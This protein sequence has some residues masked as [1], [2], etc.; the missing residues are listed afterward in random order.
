[1]TLVTTIKTSFTSGELDPALFG[2][3]DLR[4]FD[5][6]ARTLRNIVVEATGGVRRRP[7]LS[8]VKEA[9]RAL[10]L[11]A[12]EAA[13]TLLLFGDRTLA[14]IEA[15][16]TVATLTTAW[17]AARVAALDWTSIGDSLLLC[18]EEVEPQLLDRDMTGA[19]TLRSWSFDT[20]EGV[21]G[22]VTLGPFARYGAP[23]LVLQPQTP[24]F[25]PDQ[26]I[27]PLTTNGEPVGVSLKASRPFFHSGH[28]NVRFNLNGGQ[29]RII[30]VRDA[31]KADAIVVDGLDHGYAT[32]RFEEE[33]FS[34][35]R[36]WPIAVSQHQGRLVLGGSRDM[37]DHLWF[38][39]TGRPFNF[40]RGE[41]LADAS[42]AF[43]LQADRPHR[44]RHLHP[45]GRLQVFTTAGEWVVNGR[46]LTP[47]TVS[48]DAQ[49]QVGSPTGRK[50]RP[51]DVDGATLF[52][53][54]SGRD[55][56]EFIFTDTEQAYQAADIA[57]LS[58]H[59]MTAPKETAF[60][61]TGRLLFVVR[62]DGAFAAVTLD[63]NS[64]VVAWT[65]QATAGVALSVATLAGKAY[66][67]IHRFGRTFLEIWDEAAMLDHVQDRSNAT[68][69]E[70]WGGF[71]GFDGTGVTA[72]FE[73]GRS[74]TAK[75]SGG[76]VI[77]T[78]AARE[79]RLG[80]PYVHEIEPLP[81]S[82]AAGRSVAPDVLHRP[83]RHV[84]RL[85]ESEGLCLDTGTGP[86]EVRLPAPNGRGYT[87][88]VAVRALGWR[89]GTMQPPWRIVQEAPHP[90]RLLSVATE[91]K[92]S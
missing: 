85:F 71:A 92:V 6:G 76:E 48:I 12:F 64:N 46:P 23:D 91:R 54:A 84:F 66:F 56:R 21:N 65:L 13:N 3:G 86:R 50:I 75:V 89:R 41:A 9:A 69:T 24:L 40:D 72:V 38:S 61:A 67:L 45:S 19:W 28:Y 43:R 1:M 58:R 68:A 87:G 14:V 26:P 2:R 18:H 70:R 16:T 32:Q 78:R 20:A 57:L 36:G 7:G 51:L 35:A 49:T 4:A 82:G 10:R 17:T 30:N 34:P 63:R 39:K 42:I 53:G 5:E 88:D 59:L 55:L 11:V 33:A 47:E 81:Q 74:E 52:V 8:L 77:L 27:P 79:V 15:N 25:A 29:V 83:I 22:R 37:P 80:L 60:H 31:A 73:D 44:I 62:D 90:F